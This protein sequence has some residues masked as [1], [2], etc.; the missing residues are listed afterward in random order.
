[1]RLW[2]A[3]W[4][5]CLLAFAASA[6]AGDVSAPPAADPHW[7][8]DSVRALFQRSVFAHGYEHGY[9]QGFHAADQDYQ[10]GAFNRDLKTLDEFR[11]PSGYRRDFGDKGDFQ[12][13]YERGFVAGY[14]DGIHG[15]EFRGIEEA[16]RVAT[17]LG[18]TPAGPGFDRGFAVG[19]TEAFDHG[20]AAMVE[21]GSEQCPAFST[22]A[23]QTDYCDGYRRGFLLGAADGELNPQTQ[24]APTTAES[25]P[26]QP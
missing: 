8:L 5:V 7:T 11:H 2:V 23:K 22:G 6:L 26:A 10:A 15:R 9:E 21:A 12:R 19:Y 14:S 25:G 16:K 4:L 13:G 20:P 17:G 1:M 18:G 3:R 24:A